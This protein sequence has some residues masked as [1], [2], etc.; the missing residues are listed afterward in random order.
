MLFLLSLH[1]VG[2]EAARSDLC[3]MFAVCLAVI[4]F[5]EHM[6]LSVSNVSALR[7]TV[8]SSPTGPVDSFI[9]WKMLSVAN[10]ALVMHLGGAFVSTSS[11]L[12]YDVSVNNESP[13]SPF[14]S[15]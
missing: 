10:T 9:R 2:V 11:M 12:R 14:C 3:L 7:S 13:V 8:T 1:V 6:L 4:F 15:L 5:S